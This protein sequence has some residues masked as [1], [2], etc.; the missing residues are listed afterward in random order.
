MEKSKDIRTRRNRARGCG[1]AHFAVLLVL[2][3]HA[4][5][6][7]DACT[8][9]HLLH[10]IHAHLRVCQF[11]SMQFIQFSL[12]SGC[13]TTSSAR[14]PHH[15]CVPPRMF[16]IFMGLRCGSQISQAEMTGSSS[17]SQW[18]RTEEDFT[19]EDTLISSSNCSGEGGAVQESS[20][21]AF[22]GQVKGNCD[23]TTYL[24]LLGYL[25]W[26][27]QSFGLTCGVGFLKTEL[28]SQT[29]AADAGNF[30]SCASLLSKET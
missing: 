26:V 3:V 11:S 4:G 19:F 5:D 27:L 21:R 28:Q 14:A 23:S 16:H 1:C 29:N 12:D 18:M 24:A 9:S 2:D 20:S 17:G 7:L 30:D 8:M 15:A 22:F 25:N 13:A 6:F 10:W